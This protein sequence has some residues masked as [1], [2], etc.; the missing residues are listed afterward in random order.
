METK[1]FLANK[2]KY[3]ETQWEEHDCSANSKKNEDYCG[4]PTLSHSMNKH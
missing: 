2:Q 3:H 4:D 1:A